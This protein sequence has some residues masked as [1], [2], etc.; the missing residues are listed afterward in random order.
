M[1]E[2]DELL[3]KVRDKKSPFMVPE[4]Y[5]DNFSKGVDE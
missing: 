2:E 4:G 1:K 3:K 5:F